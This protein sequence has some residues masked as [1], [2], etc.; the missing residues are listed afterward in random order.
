[1]LVLRDKGRYYRVATNEASLLVCYN[2]VTTISPCNQKTGLHAMFGQYR[3]AKNAKKRFFFIAELIFW[4]F[5][6]E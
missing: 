5:C 6:T 2:K 3:D 4:V 1:M